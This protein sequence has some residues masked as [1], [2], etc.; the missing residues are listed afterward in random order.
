MLLALLSSGTA[1]RAD[2]RG[3]LLLGVFRGHES[4]R[5]LDAELTRA[6]EQRLRK[7][8]ESTTQ[9][10]ALP[11]RER[12]CASQECLDQ[13]AE[14]SGIERILGADV[15]R[16]E[17]HSRFLTVWLYDAARK[18]PAQRS[19]GC[20]RCDEDRVAS[21]LATMTAELLREHDH[22][23]AAPGPTQAPSAATPRARAQ[24][25]A[26]A[27]PARDRAPAAAPALLA[28]APGTAPV[29]PPRR[30]AAPESCWRLSRCRLAIAGT[31]VGLS[32]ASAL[33]AGLLFHYDQAPSPGPCTSVKTGGSSMACFYDVN[34]YGKAGAAVG[35][36]VLLL[37]AGLTLA[38]P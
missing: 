20:E 33:T 32:V 25:P 34:I 27:A 28:Q 24:R 12:R 7:A 18:I 35:A 5:R 30:V 26:A 36:G 8:G 23:A 17:D 14:R 4:N 11:P 37:G 1:A 19:Q 29:S 38:F 15:E 22:G 16:G 6:L 21:A 13:L 9:P 31:L 3:L 10:T 2:E